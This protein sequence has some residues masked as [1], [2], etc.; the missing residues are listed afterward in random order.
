MKINIRETTE[1]PT[2]MYW[3]KEVI[4][5]VFGITPSKRLLV[6]NRRYYRQNIANGR[7]IA[8]IA[9]IENTDV[10]CGAVCLSEELPSPDNFSGRCAYL[11]N[12]YVR[13]EYRTK[14]VCHAIVRWLVEKAKQLGCDKIYL[15]TTD[16]AR[17]LYKNIG[18]E[19]LSGFM[20][21]ADIQN[22][23]PQNNVGQ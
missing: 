6:A 2:L 23:E 1:I 15:E 8:I 14:G 4:E 11:M 20:K 17:T 22:I 10:G 12:V 21:Y 7:H 9:E 3:R 13:E 16:S 18:F 19:D 5:N